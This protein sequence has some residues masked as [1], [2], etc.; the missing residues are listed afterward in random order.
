MN[1]FTIG[2]SSANV[3]ET[4]KSIFFRPLSAQERTDARPTVSKKAINDLR[5][6]NWG[7]QS[8]RSRP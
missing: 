5:Q 8:A 7:A 3:V 2:G 6:T 1:H 4:T